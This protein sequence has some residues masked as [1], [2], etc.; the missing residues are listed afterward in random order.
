MFPGIQQASTPFVSHRA[1]GTFN[2]QTQFLKSQGHKNLQGTLNGGVT[3]EYL[4]REANRGREVAK[5]L[6]FLQPF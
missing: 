2:H 6:R 5:L 4:G 3:T 1:E